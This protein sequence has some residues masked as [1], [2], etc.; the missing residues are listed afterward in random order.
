MCATCAGLE[1]QLEVLNRAFAGGDDASDGKDT[2]MRFRTKKTV[3]VG[4]P[5]FDKSS[6]YC[7]KEK[8]LEIAE[9][10]PSDTSVVHVFICSDPVYIGWTYMPGDCYAPAH[11][12]VGSRGLIMTWPACNADV[13]HVL[14]SVVGAQ[15][16]LLSVLV[17]TL[18]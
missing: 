17:A 4:D 2:R 8:H 14:T 13:Q 15:R 5:S 10:R 12:S 11:D 16:M 6:R 3:Y 9:Y 18:L 7:F 1:L